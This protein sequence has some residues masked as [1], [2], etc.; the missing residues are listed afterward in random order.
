MVLGWLW[1]KTQHPMRK[2]TKA[3]STGGVAQVVQQGPEFKPHY[4]PP[5]PLLKNSN[6]QLI[7]GLTLQTCATWGLLF[8]TFM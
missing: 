5:L 4:Q 1:A 3:K 2:I 6:L 8:W 7:P